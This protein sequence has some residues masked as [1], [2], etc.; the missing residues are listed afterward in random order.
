MKEAVKRPVGIAINWFFDN[1]GSLYTTFII[2]DIFFPRVSNMIVAGALKSVSLTT[3]ETT[4]QLLKPIELTL[5][6]FP[7]R[8]KSKI[9]CCFSTIDLAV[10]YKQKLERGEATHITMEPAKEMDTEPTEMP[11][12]FEA[13]LN[14]MSPENRAIIEGRFTE[15]VK[16]LNV[17][18]A[19]AQKL[20][21]T[22]EQMTK[23]AEA[24]KAMLKNQVDQFIS[25]CGENYPAYNLSAVGK[26][27]V[28]SENSAELR[29]AIDSVLVVANR[30]FAEMK[31]FSPS[32][33]DQRQAKR[34][35]VE[36]V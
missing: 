7:A 17:T 6:N 35:K 26:R 16:K 34:A 20:N 29:R 9:H 15:V 11:N 14:D 19:S 24:D 5:C 31:A 27:I 25:N 23:A 21:L 13:I 30:Q 12:P 36:P 3:I 10:T 22:V 2:N 33:P 8:P 32:P 28:D 1:N 18:E 4:N